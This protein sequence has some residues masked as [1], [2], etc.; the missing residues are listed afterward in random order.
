MDR[1]TVKYSDGRYESINPVDICDNDYSMGNYSEL[2][3]KLGEYEDLEEQGKL[4]MNAGQN[5]N[6]ILCS[7]RMP[8]N[9]QDVEIT[10]V[11][12]NYLTGEKCYYTTRAFYEDGTLT[13]ENSA[14][15]WNE[16]DNWE[17]DEKTDSCIIPE[18]WFESVHFT[19]EFGIVDMPVIAWRP[20]SEPY[21]EK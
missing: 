6:W 20:I 7:D 1:L 2:V 16:T 9:E 21:R 15:C 5:N 8:E 18:G 13:T 3:K 17:C 11:R 10:Y 12:K 4:L 14:Y 19:E